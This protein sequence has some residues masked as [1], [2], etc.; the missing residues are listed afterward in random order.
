[1]SNES[2]SST[3][4]SAIAAACVRAARPKV[5]AW[6][7]VRNSADVEAS[8]DLAIKLAAFDPGRHGGEFPAA[9]AQ[10]L[11]DVFRSIALADAEEAVAQTPP[12]QT[13][14]DDD[15]WIPVAE[16][17]NRLADGEALEQILET[18]PQISR[19]GA[20]HALREAARRF[21]SYACFH[22]AVDV[23]TP[24]YPHEW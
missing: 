22:P 4:S 11:D 5:G 10:G 6:L 23:W 8:A 17:F 15:A 21:P 9:D 19:H 18:F 2:P 3:R 13:S 16:L 14:P 24:R 20:S 12:V 1:M 7:R